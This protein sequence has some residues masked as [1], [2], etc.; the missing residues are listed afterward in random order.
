[1]NESLERA[2]ASILTIGLL[3]LRNAA[4]NNDIERCKLE[5]E[6]L[7]NVPSLIKETNVN[8]HLYYFNHER[9]CYIESAKAHDKELGCENCTNTIKLYIPH[10]EIIV[11]ELSQIESF[12]RSQ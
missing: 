9:V 11:S 5:S 2:Y 4:F 1:M 3:A 10:W 6:H 8:R 12:K 7:H